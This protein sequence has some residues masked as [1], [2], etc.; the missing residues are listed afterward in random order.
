MEI[1]YTAA[2]L[3]TNSYDLNPGLAWHLN[4]TIF[5]APNGAE[6]SKLGH[7]ELKVIFVSCVWEWH[8]L[9]VRVEACHSKGPQFQSSSG[10]KIFFSRRCYSHGTK[11]MK[12]QGSE[13]MF[14]II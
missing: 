8:G 2:T 3:T 4:V 12:I 11:T 9:A 10:K 13:A 14:D 7:F 1:I 5:R 6:H